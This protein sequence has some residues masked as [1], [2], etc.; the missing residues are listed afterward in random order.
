MKK[1]I[2]LLEKKIFIYLLCTKFISK[3]EMKK[4]FSKDRKKRNQVAQRSYFN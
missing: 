3:N 2:N 1:K 4:L